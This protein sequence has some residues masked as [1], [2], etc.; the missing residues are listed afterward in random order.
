MPKAVQSNAQLLTATELEA[1]LGEFYRAVNEFND[2]YYFESHETLEELWM[3]TPWPERDFFQAIIQMAAAFVHFARGEFPGILKLLDAS[4]SKLEAS[5]SAR[6]GVDISKLVAGLRQARD[7]ISSLG[8]DRLREFDERKVPKV[9]LEAA[10]PRRR[11]RS[12]LI[13]I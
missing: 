13:P 5:P 6:F 4:T 3:V 8:P 12:S 2:G 1:R 11:T 9:S 7:E 10:H